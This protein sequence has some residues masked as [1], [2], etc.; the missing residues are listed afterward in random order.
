MQLQGA[1][2]VQAQPQLVVL[3]LAGGRGAAAA[4]ALPLCFFVGVLLLRKHHTQQVE[5]LARA[6]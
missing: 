6:G 5:H 1:A 3:V 4:R 2:R